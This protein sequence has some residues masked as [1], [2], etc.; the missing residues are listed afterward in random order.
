LVLNLCSQN[1]PKK[2][3]FFLSLLLYTIF[4]SLLYDYDYYYCLV[5]KS[6]LFIFHFYLLAPEKTCLLNLAFLWNVNQATNVVN[7]NKC[8]NSAFHKC[9]SVNQKDCRPQKVGWH[10]F[11][12]A[13][14]CCLNNWYYFRLQNVTQLSN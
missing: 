4:V 3:I 9:N 10:W 14:T 5:I 12:L 11:V 2:Q 8:F 6:I 1:S 7:L 13:F